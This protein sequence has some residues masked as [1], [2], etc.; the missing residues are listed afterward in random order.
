MFYKESKKNSISRKRVKF[1]MNFEKMSENQKK[2]KKVRL[3][4][5]TNGLRKFIKPKQNT[6][7]KS[8]NY[9]SKKIKIYFESF[10]IGFQGKNP[11]R[12]IR[13]HCKSSQK[14]HKRSTRRN[15][16]N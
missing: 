15:Y 7:K 5:F 12:Y 6:S 13:S 2:N 3:S 9:I 10:S 11:K 14:K 1:T 16:K 4:S 8:N